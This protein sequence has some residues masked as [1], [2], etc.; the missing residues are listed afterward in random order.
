ML[1]KVDLVSA[2]Q[3]AEVKSW[4]RAIVPKARIL[5]TTHGQVP[6]E[7]ILSIGE[8]TPERLGAL[9][10]RDIHVHAAD[11]GHDHDPDHAHPHDY[12]PD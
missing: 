12:A 4:I 10:K 6:L 9:E 2:E 8:Y 7:L 1:N 11:E 3:L 5:D